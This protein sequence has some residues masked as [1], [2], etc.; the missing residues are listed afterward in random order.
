MHGERL[1]NFVW[2]YNVSESSQEFADIMTDK[3]GHRHRFTVPPGSMA[4]TA[5]ERQKLYARQ[6]LPAPFVELIEKTTRPFIS[7]V[8]EVQMPKACHF[9]GKLLFV[10]DALSQFRPHIAL[11]A[12][13]AAMNALLLEKVMLREITIEQWEKRVLHYANEK[14]L[15]SRVVG[16]YAQFGGIKLLA[17]ALVYGWTVATQFI[18]GKF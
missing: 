18:S 9:G 17:A 3:S 4:P 11:S 10:G 14:R 13:Q 16:T 12:N 6:I 1:L 8:S 2:Y 7:T 15:L 5:W